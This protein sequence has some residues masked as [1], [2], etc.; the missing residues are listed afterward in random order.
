MFLTQRSICGPL[1][2]EPGPLPGSRWNRLRDRR[3]QENLVALVD[4]A[5]SKS[6]LVRMSASCNW[7]LVSGADAAACCVV[8]I[9]RMTVA[10][11]AILCACL[12]RVIT[13]AGCS[14]TPHANPNNLTSSNH[15]ESRMPYM[16]RRPTIMPSRTSGSGWMT[17]RLV[18]SSP[19]R[20][21]DSVGA[22][23]RGRYPTCPERR[24]YL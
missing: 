19:H 5:P 20:D 16:T 8:L 1:E 7:L 4:D 21:I 24:N 22:E 11:T 14:A 6:H 9:D 15:D 13:V 2:P 18:R 3:C 12:A 10:R 23:C 17:P